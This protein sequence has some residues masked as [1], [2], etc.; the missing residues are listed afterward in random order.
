MSLP[1]ASSASRSAGPAR[2]RVRAAAVPPEV[3]PTEIFR[4][5]GDPVRWSIVCQMAEV[6][7]L[8]CSTLETTL[9]VSKPTIS[10]HTKILIQAGLI[11]VRKEGR[12]FH[13]TLRRDVL[14][15]LIDDVWSLAPEPVPVRD[16]AV[17]FGP[18]TARRR[19]PP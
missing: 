8:A 1:K 2:S 6:D 7:E 13:Y 5:L 10:Y 15:A 17:S 11:S 14:R 18:A 4:A 12:H 16:G 19:K 9:D 3:G